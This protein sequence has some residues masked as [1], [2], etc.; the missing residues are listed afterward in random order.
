[1]LLLLSQRSHPSV[2]GLPVQANFPPEN[3]Q[4]DRYPSPPAEVARLSPRPKQPYLHQDV[5]RPVAGPSRPIK[6]HA[7]REGAV[8]LRGPSSSSGVID[9]DDS[10]SDSDSFDFRVE[11]RAGHE[12]VAITDCVK[13]PF[14]EARLENSLVPASAAT[15]P[16]PTQPALSTS[17]SPV[18][19]PKAFLLPQS[20]SSSKDKELDFLDLRKIA[21]DQLLTLLVDI[22]PTHIKSVI[23]RVAGQAGGAAAT[24]E[25]LVDSAMDEVFSDPKGYPKRRAKRKADNLDIEDDGEGEGGSSTSGGVKKKKKTQFDYL[26]KERTSGGGYNYGA[27]SQDF[28]VGEF[29]L[30]PVD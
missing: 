30:I 21:L 29:P 16:A 24:V 23:D 26:S 7:A 4:G 20:P 25:A 14:L 3:P 2:S 15:V 28:L 18:P 27:L 19:I 6:V 1:M 11:A 9:V 22:D 8:A 17:A 13:A 5:E 12:R 10:S